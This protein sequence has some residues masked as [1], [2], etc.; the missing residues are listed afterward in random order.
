VIQPE[1]NRAAPSVGSKLPSFSIDF[2]AKKLGTAI[3]SFSGSRTYNAPVGSG[4]HNHFW[5][6]TV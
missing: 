5:H 3:R 2:W 6:E 1:S 4:P